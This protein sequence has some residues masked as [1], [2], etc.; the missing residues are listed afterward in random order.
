MSDP[1]IVLA[2]LAA[3]LSLGAWLVAHRRHRLTADTPTSNIASAVQG[4]VELKGRAE[5]H[6]SAPLFS[7][8]RGLPCVWY[9]Y[10]VQERR[11][12]TWQTIQQT[13]SDSTFLL[14]DETGECIV[15]PDH[16]EILTRHS[17]VKH[18]GDQRFME[19]LLLPKDKL[20]ALGQFKTLNP[21]DTRLD[22]RED[23][24]NLLAEWKQNRPALLDR[25]D[26][27]R[28]GD[29]DEQEWRLARAQAK[30]EVE[31]QHREL[32]A[33]PG[34]HILVAPSDGRRFLITNRDPEGMTRSLQ[35]WS[36]FFMGSFVLSLGYFGHLIS[37]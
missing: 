34:F 19:F 23:V 22:P 17:D 20:Y 29:I 35:R 4:Y 8:I 9:R 1:G 25:F 26:L 37:Q 2:P 16:A 10:L 28:D 24:G 31:K 12:D 30:R 3:C 36:W 5:A 7:R 18:V 11:N 13:A 32:R 14:R 27:N 6:P 21:V 15:D 33:Q